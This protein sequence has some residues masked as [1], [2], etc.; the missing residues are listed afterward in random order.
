[1]NKAEFL[2]KISVLVADMVG[3]ALSELDAQAYDDLISNHEVIQ[4]IERLDIAVH[5]AT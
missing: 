2:E 1:M 3:N 5:E 4:L